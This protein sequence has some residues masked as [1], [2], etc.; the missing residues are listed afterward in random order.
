MMI[1]E[2]ALRTAPGGADPDPGRRRRGPRAGYDVMYRE[3]R[4]EPP[5]SRNLL[6]VDSFTEARMATILIVDD[7][8]FQRSFLRKTLSS[9]GY[10]VLEARN[11]KEGLR[12]AT[13]ESPDCILADLIMPETRGLTMLESLHEKGIATPVVV[14]TAD[15]QEQ[16]KEQCLALGARAVLYKPVDPE[17]LRRQVAEILGDGGAG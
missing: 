8:Q 3:S 2:L 10:R 15:I 16:V 17:G 1:L 4:P 9:A 6:I 11:G 7:S 14:V 13:E 12:L 5:T